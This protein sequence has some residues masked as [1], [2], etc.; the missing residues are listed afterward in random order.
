MRRQFNHADFAQPITYE[1]MTLP[2]DSGDA[3][4][5]AT[6]G[7]MRRYALED[8][9]SSPVASLAHALLSECE[10]GRAYLQAVFNAANERMYFQRDE[11][12]GAP[13]AGDD[14][15]EVLLRPVDVLTLSDPGAG[16]RVPGDCDCFSMFVAA[17]L[18]A[19]GVDCAF[20]TA[21]ASAKAPESFSHVYVVAWPQTK[22]RAV[23]DAS[24]GTGIDWEAPNYGRYQ[25]WPVG[26]SSLSTGAGSSSCVLGLLLSLGGAL[27]FLHDRAERKQESEARGV[28]A[29]ELA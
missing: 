10:D 27:L 26:A 2:E 14:T 6:V 22:Y 3:Q 25:E 5:T 19:G 20:A 21:G 7:M 28:F 15:V 13:I 23:V 12:T 1:A 18:L 4:V 16:I 9:R 8:S 24:H 17:L 11:V 29:G